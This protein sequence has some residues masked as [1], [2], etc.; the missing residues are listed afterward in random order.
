MCQYN[1]VNFACGHAPSVSKN[2]CQYPCDH[3]EAKHIKIDDFC[4]ECARALQFSWGTNDIA[5]GIDTEATAGPST[6][7]YGTPV[8]YADS[9]P[10]QYGGEYP[11]INPEFLTL[12]DFDESAIY[13]MQPSFYCPQGFSNDGTN[14]LIDTM[15]GDFA[16]SLPEHTPSYFPSSAT[17]MSYQTFPNT[18]QDASSDIQPGSDVNRMNGIANFP[19]MTPMPFG[20]V[21]FDYQGPIPA[22]EES[23][24]CD[25]FYDTRFNDRAI[26]SQTP[27]PRG[28]SMLEE[29]INPEDTP[30]PWDLDSPEHHD[31]SYSLLASP[32][33][34][35]DFHKCLPSNKSSPEIDFLDLMDSPDLSPEP[36]PEIMTPPVTDEGDVV[37]VG[38]QSQETCSKP[39][40]SPTKPRRRRKPKPLT[41]RKYAWRKYPK[42]LVKQEAESDDI[43]PEGT[44]EEISTK[45]SSPSDSKGLQKTKFSICDPRET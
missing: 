33:R 42:Q 8:E 43:T 5:P 37:L 30:L 36:Q 39:P 29:G 13:G 15:N 19:S 31:M 35:P 18:F 12:P 3:Q 25:S 10:Y 20:A 14:A 11:T 17:S 16:P 26:I 2:S 9:Q 4:P 21:P 38:E 6:G 23:T 24:G 40:N 44:N 34:Q 1:L 28:K 22:K 7:Y 27:C 41:T 32:I 45:D